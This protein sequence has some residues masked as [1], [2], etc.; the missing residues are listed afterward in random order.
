MAV[1]KMIIWG[2]IGFDLDDWKE[3]LEDEYPEVTDETAQYELAWDMNM[4]Y[5]SD[6]RM[7]LDME[8]GRIVVIAE[9]GLWFGVRRAYKMLKS[10]N[11]KDI[12]YSDRDIVYAEWFVEDG[13]LRGTGIHHDGTNQYLYRCLDRNIDE[14]LIIDIECGNASIEDIMKHS[15]SL[16]PEVSKVYGWDLVLT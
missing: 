8:V 6:E 4:E 3:F 5:L 11:L 7:N 16:A 12:L 1:K 14:E 13:E 9:L 10:R 2:D 15:H